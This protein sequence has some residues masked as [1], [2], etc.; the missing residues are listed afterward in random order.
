MIIR[1]TQN[2]YQLLIHNLNLPPEEN[3]LLLEDDVHPLVKY[4]CLGNQPM[5]NGGQGLPG[6]GNPVLSMPMFIISRPLWR[7]QRHRLGWPLGAGFGACGR[8]GGCI[9]QLQ[10]V[11]LGAIALLGCPVGS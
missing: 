8:H 2:I 3:H 9:G 4:W 6:F 10:L 1:S 7:C 11:P 5:K